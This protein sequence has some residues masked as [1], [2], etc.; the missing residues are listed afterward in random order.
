MSMMHRIKR[1]AKK[2]YFEILNAKHLSLAP[3]FSWVL[4]RYR[5]I[6]TVSTVF[7]G[8]HGTSFALLAKCR[9]SNDSS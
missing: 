7:I 3:N 2:T 5:E 9:A 8:S 1:S 6:E 4:V